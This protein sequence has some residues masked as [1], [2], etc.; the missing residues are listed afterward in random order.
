MR[1]TYTRS[2]NHMAEATALLL[3]AIFPALHPD[4]A[5]DVAITTTSTQHAVRRVHHFLH[6]LSTLSL[7]PGIPEQAKQL[8]QAH[9]EFTR[10]TEIQGTQILDVSHHQ[11]FR[12][13]I[14]PVLVDTRPS[15]AAIAEALASIIVSASTEALSSSPAAQSASPLKQHAVHKPR[16]AFDSV[17]SGFLPST[18]DC[19]PIPSWLPRDDDGSQVLIAHRPYNELHSSRA[20]QPLETFGDVFSQADHRCSLAGELVREGESEFSERWAD[21]LPFLLR[22]LSSAL[23]GMEVV[24]A[25]VN[26]PFE[27]L[28]FFG[29]CTVSHSGVAIASLTF[30]EK[31]TEVDVVR[32]QKRDAAESHEPTATSSSSVHDMLLSVKMK[33][34]NIVL[35][36]I[37][38]TIVEAS[39]PNAVTTETVHVVIKNVKLKIAGDLLMSPAGRHNLVVQTSRVTIGNLK[40]KT[41]SVGRNAFLFL[42]K[43]LIRRAVEKEVA[44]ALLGKR[45]L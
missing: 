40:I 37:A 3:R 35:T 19:T 4:V 12:D 27:Q 22:G 8:K 29:R 43:R 30:D 31:C 20:T 18:S 23:N 16:T 15:D 1:P 13:T 10:F 21:A 25:A 28:P 36:P 45:V 9:D 41:T 39:K 44:S 7:D 33:H 11:Q 24:S 32:R 34:V 17:P 26:L 6:P 38:V 14:T 5:R 42:G 2:I